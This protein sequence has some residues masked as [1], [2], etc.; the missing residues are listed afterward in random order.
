MAIAEVKFIVSDKKLF[1]ALKA[2]EGIA[3]QPP[4]VHVPEGV[5]NGGAA[6]KP[7]ERV[8]GG[9]TTLVRNY[10]KGKKSVVA[11]DLRKETEAHGYRKGSYSYAL[12]IMTK[13]G[14]LKLNKK[15]GGYDVL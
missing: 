4:V 9:V 12:K 1:A 15:T 6:P 14:E 10:I 3:L 5:V 11:N 13:A 8:P 7:V 2:L